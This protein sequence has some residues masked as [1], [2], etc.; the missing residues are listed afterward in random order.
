MSK[1]RGAVKPPWWKSGLIYQIYV[2]SFAD[3]NNDGIGDLPGITAHLDYLNDGTPESL[4]V[5]AIWLTPFYQSPDRDFGYDVSDYREVHPQHGTM[6]DF[7]RLLDEAHQRG[8]RVIIDF[9]PNHTSD[10]HPWFVES[11]ESRDSA[12]RDWYVWADGK[13]SGPPNN[14]QAAPGGGAWQFDERTGQYFYHAFFDFQPDLN[15]RNHAVRDAVYD[16][17][18]FWMDKG[19]DGLR[20]DLINYLVED[21][22]LRDNR[23][24]AAGW[25]FGKFQ[26]SVHTRDLKET[27]DILA[28]F[29]ALMDGYDERMMVGEVVSFPWEDS[30]AAE[31]TGSRELHLAFNME[32]LAVTRFHA[33][34]FRTVVDRFERRLAADGWP[35]YVLSNHDMPRHLGRMAGWAIYGHRRH[36]MARGKV[37]AAMLLTLRGTPFLYYGEELGMTNRWWPRSRVQDPMGRKA[38]PIYQGRDASRTPMLWSTVAGAGFTTGRPWLDIDPEA[39][40]LCV[41][42]ADRDPASLLNFY[43]RLVWLR[44]GTPALQ[45]GTYE[46]L[47]DC[48]PSLFAYRRRTGAQSILVALNFSGRVV[49]VPSGID[50]RVL[51]SSEERGER[52]K[53][54]A[55][56]APY[57]V[58]VCEE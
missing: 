37:C 32:F 45:V 12:K 9:V 16:D 15:W 56:L 11:R 22:Q 26:D 20:L 6:G 39:D 18:R 28:E 24:T 54:S 1:D 8:I 14:W 53:G 25:Y 34:A 17:I 57:E 4:G 33:D 35:A 48:G 21:E 51:L 43:R 2:R 30:A 58:L 36:A 13:G 55:R 29:R 19:V 52:V 40:R 44:K 50:A 10:E 3:S 47:D 38:W 7:D 49:D 41:E 46:P 5:D 23:F 31:Y 42:A 27:H